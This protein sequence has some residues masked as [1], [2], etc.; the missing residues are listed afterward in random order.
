MK[1][2]ILT[3]KGLWQNKWGKLDFPIHLNPHKRVERVFMKLFDKYFTH[4]NKNKKTCLEI[5]CNPGKFLIYCGKNLN[6]EMVGLD[7]DKIGTS[8]TK[9]NFAESGLEAECLEKDFFNYDTDRKF[10]LILSLGFIEHFQ[11]EM[12]KESINRHV[13]LL[14]K[15]GKLFLSVPNF[16]YINYIFA[17]IF[18]KKILKVHNLEVM[19]KSFF[20]D[21]ANNNNLEI[22]YLDYFGG[23]HP[24]GLKIGNNNFLSKFFTDFL[25]FNYEKI[26]ILDNINSKFFSHHLG[27]IY[28]KN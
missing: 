21:I 13:N 9:K 24:G 10:D 18:R 1:K 15:G 12:L 17:Y 3:D 2:T 25:I 8:I 27:A 6:Y 28:K 7:Y 20:I 4:N 5:G 22:E 26:N 19:Q 16:K 14:N 11:G 23:F